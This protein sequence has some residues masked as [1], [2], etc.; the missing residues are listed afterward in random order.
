MERLGRLIDPFTLLLIGTVVAASLL[1]P[2][3][4]M[5]GVFG[6]A[7]DIAIA[8]LFFLHGA[9]L[10]RQAIL[11]G[12]GH[13]RLHLAVLVS[14]FVLFP[15]LGVGTRWIATPFVSPTILAGMVYLCLLPSTVQS[16]IAFT[17][18]GRGNVPAAICSAT[19]S[20]LLGVVITPLLVALCLD[21]TGEVGPGGI[22]Q[23]VRSIAVQLLAPFILGHLCRPLLIGL[24]ERRKRLVGIVDR[25]SILLVVYAAFG[26]AVVDGIW[27]KLTD[28]D[29]AAV[30]ILSAVILLIAVA[31]T[32]FGGRLAG[33]SRADRVALVFCGSKKSMITGIPMAGV[34]FPPA[35]VGGLILPL[36]IFHQMQLML[37]AVLARRYAAH[38][39]DEGGGD[40]W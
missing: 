38:A 2:R 19:L 6:A 40:G 31:A 27:A 3:G 16:S 14:T 39:A 1:P 34:L 20:N 22:V 37:C 21:P 36:M 29:L 12:M 32:T 13:W 17:A 25:G 28:R 33:F 4:A 8:L 10:S 15:I 24:L 5:T 9:K 30:L 23:A 26:A 11:A 7:T 18:M 35:L